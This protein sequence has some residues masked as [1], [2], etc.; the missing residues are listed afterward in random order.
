MGTRAENRSNAGLRTRGALR[1]AQTVVVKVGSAVLA[2][3]PAVIARLSAALA[4]QRAAG[5]RVVLVTSGAIALGYRTLGL[6]TRPTDVPS[7]Q[8]AAAIGQTVLMGRWAAGLGEAGLHGAQILLTHA[9]LKSRKRYLNAR[10]ALGRL[11]DAGVV[12]IVNENDTVA[13]EEITLGD[14]DALAAEVAGLVLADVVVLLTQTDGFF[15]A[16][17]HTDPT[18]TRIA[19]LEAIDADALEKAGGAAA[20]GTGGMRTKVLAARTAR[21]HGAATVIASGMRPGQLAAV[22]RGDDVGTFVPG[23]AVS[24]RTARKRWLA[25][26]L[27]PQGTLHVDAG[28]EAAVMGG[29]SLLPAGLT[30]VDGAFTAGELVA[31]AGPRGGVF[32]RGLVRT[33]AVRARAAC[34]QRVAAVRRFDTYF[35]DVLVHRDDLVLEDPRLSRDAA[36][37]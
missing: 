17:P 30:A 12:P 21:S 33:G 32:A 15:T 16:D 10:A 24:P 13:V 18:A 31:L 8:A 6:E 7:L 19:T 4:A 23:P 20:L 3:G 29:A 22:M 1:D 9:D 25:H 14:N 36:D 26:T 11:L 35:P 37:A 27:R 2:G 28:A 5:R 34:G